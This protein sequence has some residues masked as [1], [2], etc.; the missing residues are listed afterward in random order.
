[1]TSAEVLILIDLSAAGHVSADEYDA[2]V[3][4]RMCGRGLIDRSTVGGV[5]L[6]PRGRRV[7]L[8]YV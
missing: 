6:T 4:A 8:R 1:M 2:A 5:F 3:V 7:A